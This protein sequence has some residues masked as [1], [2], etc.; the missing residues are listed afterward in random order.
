M[1]QTLSAAQL[2]N[3]AA[4]QVGGRWLGGLVFFL[5]GF[6]RFFLV[7]SEVF[8]VFWGVWVGFSSFFFFLGGGE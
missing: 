1:L 7:F 6:P 3:G 5:W 8:L 2:A 4:K